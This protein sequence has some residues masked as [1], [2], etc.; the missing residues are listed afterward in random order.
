MCAVGTNLRSSV[1]A[2]QPISI[3]MGANALGGGFAGAGRQT[4]MGG[5][6]GA[7]GQ[8]GSGTLIAGGSTGI[9]QD[10]KRITPVR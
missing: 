4:F 3:G 1:G 5:A 8:R 7:G 9:G 2:S 10:R 6:P